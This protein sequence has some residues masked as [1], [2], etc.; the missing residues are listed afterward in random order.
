MDAGVQL[1]LFSRS[2]KLQNTDDSLVVQ[3]IVRRIEEGNI[4]DRRWKNKGKSC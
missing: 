3:E 2:Y 4:F 1:S